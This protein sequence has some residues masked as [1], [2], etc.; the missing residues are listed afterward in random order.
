ME[1]E[2]TSLT[3]IPLIKAAMNIS[4]GQPVAWVTYPVG[5]YIPITCV[6]RIVKLHRKGVT[7]RIFSPG[8]CKWVKRVTRTRNLWEIT[9]EQLSRLERLERKVS[10]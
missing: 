1:R 2:G 7:I 9:D 5:S 3:P 4:V 10:P 8:E 6:A